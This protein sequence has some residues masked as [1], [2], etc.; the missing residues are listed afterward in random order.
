MW[1]QQEGCNDRYEHS[2][3]RQDETILI[4]QRKILFF[5]SFRKYLP[6]IIW[7]H[8]H[9]IRVNWNKYSFVQAAAQDIIS[10]HNSIKLHK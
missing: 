9:S 1:S 4:L 7:C 8:V 3:K 10:P 6:V 5:L 2:L